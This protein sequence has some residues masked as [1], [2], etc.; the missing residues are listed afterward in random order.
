MLWY[1]SP[2]HRQVIN[3]APT[4]PSNRAAEFNLFAFWAACF[5]ADCARKT[6]NIRKPH[7]TT[8]TY[9]HLVIKLHSP[10]FFP[11]LSLEAI[12]SFLSETSNLHERDTKSSHVSPCF[13]HLFF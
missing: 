12:S 11:K 4:I 7:F 6:E 13:T 10:Y 2:L 5:L 9:S 8:S 1:L 3:V